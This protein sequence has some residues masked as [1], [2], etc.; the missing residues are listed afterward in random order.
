MKT[1]IGAAVILALALGP[2]VGAAQQTTRPSYEREIPPALLAQVKISEDSARALA[3]AKVPGGLE[4]VELKRESGVL[5][6]IWDVHVK[7]K[8]GI[9]EVWVNAIDGT[10]SSHEE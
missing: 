10:V 7:G 9:T 6:W 5:V 8:R 3:L 1:M 4:A 2:R